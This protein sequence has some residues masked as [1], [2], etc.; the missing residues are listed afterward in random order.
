VFNLFDVR[1]EEKGGEN[2]R[3]TLRPKEK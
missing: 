3:E 1:G 2:Q